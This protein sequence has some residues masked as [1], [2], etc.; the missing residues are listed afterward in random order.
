M[1]ETEDIR[2]RGTGIVG[3]S[4]GQAQQS[5]SFSVMVHVVVSAVSYLDRIQALLD[6][7]QTLLGH[8][9][10]VRVCRIPQ[11]IRLPVRDQHRCQLVALIGEEQLRTL[12]VEGS[13]QLWIQVHQLRGEQHIGLLLLQHELRQQRG[14]LHRKVL[15]SERISILH[16][17]ELF[18]NLPVLVQVLQESI[19][20]VSEPGNT[21]QRELISKEGTKIWC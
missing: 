4:K 7:V 19:R 3:T 15:G 17:E 16:Q 1:Q 11:L 8:V 13:G 2:W 14:R 12:R 18:K 21:E 5:V 10:V 20:S 6:R 9:G